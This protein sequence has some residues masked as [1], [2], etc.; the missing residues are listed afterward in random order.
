MITTDIGA[1]GI[2]GATEALIV[3][4][5]AE[6]MAKQIVHYYANND[7]LGKLSACGRRLVQN[8]FSKDAVR[9]VIA[10]DFLL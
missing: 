4:N 9:K 7:E 6:T 3:A 5:D 2:P 8:N 1:E 10:D